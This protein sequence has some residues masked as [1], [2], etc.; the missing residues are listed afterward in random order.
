MIVFLGFIFIISA[1]FLIYNSEKKVDTKFE[2]VNISEVKSG[3]ENLNLE[4]SIKN[5]IENLELQLIDVNYEISEDEILIVLHSKREMGEKN[6][7]ALSILPHGISSEISK[8]I[9]V[10]ENATSIKNIKTTYFTGKGYLKTEYNIESKL[11]KYEHI[12][13]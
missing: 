10:N 6:E 9:D 3:R 11:F 13:N 12:Q 8:S 2:P 7:E 5:I 1:F 4:S